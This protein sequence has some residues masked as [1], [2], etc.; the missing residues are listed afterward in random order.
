MSACGRCCR[1]EDGTWAWHETNVDGQQT[2]FVAFS[3]GT[4]PVGSQ[5]ARYCKV[6]PRPLPDSCQGQ[7][8]T[9]PF[10]PVDRMCEAIAL[11]C[12]ITTLI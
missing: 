6:V 11:L 1:V 10:T 4:P 3:Q 8:R 9:T 12:L 5:A 2:G 7:S